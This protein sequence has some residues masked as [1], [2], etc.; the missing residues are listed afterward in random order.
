MV[1]TFIFLTFGFLAFAFY[2]LSGGAD[3]EPASGRITSEA[4]K[5]QET[6]RADANRQQLAP[7]SANN[8]ENTIRFNATPSV[9]DVSLDLT[10]VRDGAG[11][12]PQPRRTATITDSTQT[13]QIILPSLIAS[14]NTPAPSNT[15][16]TSF[17]GDVRGDVRVVS[18]NRVNVRGGPSTTY[19]VINK[20]N[21]GAKVRILE[22]NGDGWVRMQ[23]LDGG[24]SGWLADFL[25][26]ES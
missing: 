13:P 19:G 15:A 2:Q 10:D 7:P 14:T 12:A 26:S 5:P 3:F 1:K 17:D 24:E 20:L 11:A 21:R 18:G 16:A 4:E 25:L 22:D 6:I 23:A 8:T 9:T